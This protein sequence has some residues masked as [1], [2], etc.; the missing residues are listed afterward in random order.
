[1]SNKKFAICIITKNRNAELAFTIGKLENMLGFE[2]CNFYIF[3]DGENIPYDLKQ[4]F[5]FV[6]WYS[7]DKSLGASLA[8]KIML[9]KVNEEI[10]IGFDDDSHPVDNDFLIVIEQ[11]FNENKQLGIIAFSEIKGIYNDIELGNIKLKI[12]QQDVKE[13]NEFIGCGYALVNKY[14]KMTNGFPEFIDIYGEESF[15]S[16]EIL[17]L[18][19]KILYYPK[20]IVHHRVDRLKR[21]GSGYNYFRF[22]KQLKNAMLFY[23]RYYPNHIFITKIFGLLYHNFFKYAI[24]NYRYFWLFFKAIFSYL[25]IILIAKYEVKNKMTVNVISDFEKIKSIKMTY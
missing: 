10:I 7:S 18:K 16:M 8:R 20:L 22:E 23:Y 19:L 12:I 4:K 1:M 9:E 6:N 11:L 24:K 13:V 25:H 3:F 5:S 2:K 14:Y 17:A 15:V 21:A